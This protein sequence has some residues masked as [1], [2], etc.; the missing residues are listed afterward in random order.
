MFHNAVYTVLEN[1]IVLGAKVATALLLSWLIGATAQGE[2]M[3]FAAS[4]ALTTIFSVV[5][6]DTSS[7]Y[8]RARLRSETAHAAVAGNALLLALVMGVTGTGALAL[9]LKYTMLLSALSDET[10]QFLFLSILPGTLALTLGSLIYGADRFRDHFIGTSLH[11]GVFLIG[12][13]SFAVQG[14]LTVPAAIFW[15]LIGL[16]LST[17]YWAVIVWRDAGNRL[18]LNLKMLRRQFMYGLRAAPYFVTS[19]TNF[20][21]DNFL[22]VYY[23]GLAPLGIYSIAAAATEVFLYLPRSLANVVLTR[24]SP[25]WGDGIAPVL[26]ILSAAFL[27]LFIPAAILIP[28]AILLLFSAE[29]EQARWVA[30][31]LLPA[32][33]PMAMA[34]VS[35]FYLFGRGKIWQAS[36]AA[37]GGA[38]VTVGA[39][40]LLIPVAGLY[41]AGIASVLSYSAFLAVTLFW[42]MRTDQLDVKEALRPDFKG[43]RL[44]IKAVFLEFFPQAHDAR[45]R[46]G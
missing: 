8:W 17:G 35:C 9:V 46:D 29:F 5:G 21:A 38:L 45:Q 6:L 27:T 30:L 16:L 43:L 40:A 24:Y 14:Q 2:Y 36:V 25:S 37:S 31:I 33:Y 28:F 41:G 39:N 22:I 18:L 10:A 32:T 44:T 15:W 3:L 7:N 34:I 19:A 20:R 42:L 26:R 23:L 12:A 4:Y 11:N 1:A 13:L